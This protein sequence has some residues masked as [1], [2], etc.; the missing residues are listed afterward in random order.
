MIDI[1]KIQASLCR[2][3]CSSISVN[4]VP[5]GYAVSTAFEDSSGD[6]LRFYVIA[7]GDH[8]RLEDGG[9]FL[10]T[11]R[12]SGID[13]DSGQRGALLNQVL[14]DGLSYWDQDSFEIRTDEFSEK[15][16]AGRMI[17]FT[18]ALIRARDVGLLTREMVRST[19]REDAVRIL[20]ERYADQF[21]ANDNQAVDK[22]FKDYPSDMVLWGKE[23]NK[24]AA[25]YFVSNNEKL[26]EAQLMMDE[27][28]RLNRL[29]VNVIALIEGLEKVS[30]RKFQRAQNRGLSMP[31]F[32]GDEAAAIQR[33]GETIGLTV[34]R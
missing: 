30:N 17:K 15:E 6:R 10:A 32:S 34:A 9:D 5:C 13:F 21:T 16:L 14:Q 31:I 8:Y 22:D 28:R 1:E 24:V 29:D 33:V 3:F 2:T 23:T 25:L 27:A 19:F 12:A 7:D 26:L 18:A 20:D 11:L 4:T